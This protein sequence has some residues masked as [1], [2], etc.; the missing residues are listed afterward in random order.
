M[1][2][3]YLRLRRL[4]F[5]LETTVSLFNR[6]VRSIP[7]SH[8]SDVVWAQ[9]SRSS[10]I[11]YLA[12]AMGHMSPLSRTLF[13]NYFFNPFV[14]FRSSTQQSHHPWTLISQCSISQ[15][16][17][18]APP[19]VI[20]TPLWSVSPSRQLRSRAVHVCSLYTQHRARIPK[21]VLNK[22]K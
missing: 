10:S 7:T 21:N 17:R 12:Q 15:W 3:P 19:I 9:P 1:S 4:R 22:R 18:I 11:S 14:L 5:V 16:H 2:L 8:S 6:H 20:A 13:Y